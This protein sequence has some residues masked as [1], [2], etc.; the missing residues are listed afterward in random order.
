M[1]FGCMQ[2]RGVLQSCRIVPLALLTV[3]LSACSSL[4]DSSG[5]PPKVAAKL[6]DFKQTARLEVRWHQDIGN[7]GRDGLQPAV[8]GD[9]I[10]AANAKGEVFRFER[11]T[12]KQVWRANAGF[13]ITGGVGAGEGLVLVGNGKGDLAAFAENGKLQWKVRISSEVLSAPQVSA[14]IVVVRTGDGRIAGLNVSDGK[15]QWLYE[16]STPSLIVRS[17]GGVSISHGVV[18][19]GFAAGRLAAINLNTGA[20]LWE[21]AVSQPRG[22]TELERISD[23]TSTP[24]VDD[25][26]VCAIAFQGRVGCFELKQG[27]LLWSRELSSDKGIALQGKYLYV[28]DSNGVI[29]A[30]DKGSGSSLWKNEQLSLRSTSAP[31][32]TQ[33]YIMVGDF[34]GYLHALGREDGS[35]ASRMRADSSPILTAPIELDGGLLLQTSGGGLYSLRIKD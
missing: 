34:E 14:G 6:V 15:R 11:A 30:L 17:H 27:S 7:A 20:V 28:S 10:Y 1:T 29:S 12:G 2:V 26:Q 22:N 32:V 9:A 24:V 18:Y 21:A 33:K 35:M 3:W 5:P 31:Y 8:T 25:D 16:R 19:A 23:I 4:F 13:A